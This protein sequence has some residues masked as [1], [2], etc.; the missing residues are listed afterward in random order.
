M[1]L[2]FGLFEC[3]HVEEDKVEGVRR[4][5][6]KEEARVSEKGSNWYWRKLYIETL[7]NLFY[8]PDINGILKEKNEKDGS[9]SR[10]GREQKCILGLV[11]KP[12]EKRQL[13]RNSLK[14]GDITTV[15]LT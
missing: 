4:Y 7:V 5:Y 8:S 1:C 11:K 12:E 13:G 15:D 6:G 3:L 9:R 10:Y 14:R 2:Y